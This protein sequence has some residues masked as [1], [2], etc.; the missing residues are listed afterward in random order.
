MQ[1]IRLLTAVATLAVLVWPLVANGGDRHLITN[2]R[3]GTVGYIEESP[4]GSGKMIVHDRAGQ[5]VRVIE[6]DTLADGYVIQDRVG[7]RI[8]PVESQTDDTGELRGHQNWRD[9]PAADWSSYAD[10]WGQ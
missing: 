5:A 9:G 1:P 6:R 2:E 8:G 3:G 4:Y 7:N 10:R